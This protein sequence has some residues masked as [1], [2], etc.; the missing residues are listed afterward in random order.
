MFLWPRYE[1]RLFSI[2]EGAARAWDDKVRKCG[3][4]IDDSPKWARSA[5]EFLDYY[6]AAVVQERARVAVGVEDTGKQPRFGRIFNLSPGLYLQVVFR[7]NDANIALA[8]SVE[9]ALF[10]EDAERVGRSVRR[11]GGKA[12]LVAW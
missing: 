11:L 8:D 6:W 5:N 7:M 2:D 10:G 4:E 3:F 1:Q 9:R 12:R